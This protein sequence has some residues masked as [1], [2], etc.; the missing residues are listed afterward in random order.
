MSAQERKEL[1]KLADSKG[2]NESAIVRMLVKE[3]VEKQK[4]P[5]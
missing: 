1:K 3:A 5:S 2:L 4:K